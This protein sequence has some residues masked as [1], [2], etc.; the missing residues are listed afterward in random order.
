MGIKEYA[1]IM[2]FV[3]TMQ[4]RD[5]EDEVSRAGCYEREQYLDGVITGLRIALE[6]LDKSSFLAE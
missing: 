2:R 4:I 5:V 6:K 1:D 3:L